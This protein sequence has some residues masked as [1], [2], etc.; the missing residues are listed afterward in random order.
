MLSC[1]P[2]SVKLDGHDISQYTQE[3][4]RGAIGIVPQDTVL[5]NDTILYNIQYGRRDA[6]FEE[7]TCNDSIVDD[8]HI[9]G[10]VGH[11]C[12]RSSSNKEFHRVPGRR[13]EHISRRERAKAERRRKA[14]SGYRTLSGERFSNFLTSTS[15]YIVF[16]LA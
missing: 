16:L 2:G 10:T 8:T 13:L 6:T 14:T 7:V 1:L 12:R 3:S 15:C 11:G 4:V 5:F 9:F